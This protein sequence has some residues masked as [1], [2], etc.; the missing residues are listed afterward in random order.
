MGTGGHGL[1]LPDWATV[2]QINSPASSDPDDRAGEPRWGQ[3]EE[4][5]QPVPWACLIR[6]LFKRTS[7]RN[8]LT[9][10]LGKYEHRM[11]V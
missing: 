8:R 7:H 10:H 9:E 4:S 11:L 3:I 1:L 5:C 6:F 2:Y